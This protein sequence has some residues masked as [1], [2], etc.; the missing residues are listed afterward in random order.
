MHVP[1][2]PINHSDAIKLFNILNPKTVDTFKE[3]ET[4]YAKIIRY[5]KL[6]KQLYFEVAVMYP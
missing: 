4:K 1:K 3:S 2:R 6:I 5:N